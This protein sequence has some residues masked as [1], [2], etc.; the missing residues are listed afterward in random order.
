MGMTVVG[1][2][3]L[4]EQGKFFYHGVWHW[5][6]L[7]EY[8]EH[9]APDLIPA[10]NLGYSNDGWGLNERD[11]LA[12]ADRLNKA[13]ASGETQI[14]EEGY[15][16]LLET[17]PPESC[18]FCGGTEHRAPLPDHGPGLL[19]C[20]HCG[21]TGTVANFKT[22]FSFTVENVR[23]FAAFLRDCGGFQIY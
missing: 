22:N 8:C 3:P 17:L 10:D 19:H 12:L 9:V 13:L 14:Y 16:I 11:A 18:E 23:Q 5:H 2:S 15:K 1:L 7:W 21:G 4:S 20:S 6:P